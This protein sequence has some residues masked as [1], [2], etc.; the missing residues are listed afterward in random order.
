MYSHC[1]AVTGDARAGAAAAEAAFLHAGPWRATLW[2]HARHE[3][4]LRSP[5]P[6]D[7][8]A[9]DVADGADVRDVA[10]LLAATRPATERAVLDLRTRVD[11]VGFARALGMAVAGA[12]DRADALARDWDR[13]LDPALLAHLGPGGCDDLAALLGGGDRR[14]AGADDAGADDGGDDVAPPAEPARTDALPDGPE[15]A[16]PA[17]GSRLPATVAELLARGQAVA[18]H[19]AGCERCADRLRAMVSVRALAL[20]GWA[21]APAGVRAEARRSRVR[22]PSGMPPGLDPAAS[23]RRM[24]I[25]AAAAMVLVLLAAA[26]AGFVVVRDG[27]DTGRSRVDALTRRP[28]Q[29]NILDVA[30]SPLDDSQAT[31]RI[32][33]KGSREVRWR[34]DPAAP[35]LSVAP[36][37]GRVAPG[38]T[39]YAV[40]QVLPSSPEGL[41]RSSVTV[42]GNDGSVAAADLRWI[43]EREPELETSLAACAVRAAVVEDGQVRSVT[44]HWRNGAEGATEMSAAGDDVW[45]A[46]L[47]PSEEPLAWWV[48]AVDDRGNTAHSGEQAATPTATC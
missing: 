29:G 17:A 37:S 35:W 1:E 11:R 43:V 45:T 10:R 24:L 8:A 25:P 32:E 44:L 34:A 19:A 7:P 38:Q 40:V 41:L 15:P 21:I 31:L 30:A 13:T 3:S 39:A 36:T 33:N 28:A 27:G 12:A 5:D 26:I 6:L 20:S 23:T 18:T 16:D 22:R 42:T 4:L 46:S 2:A 9:V 48:T 47:P 14:R